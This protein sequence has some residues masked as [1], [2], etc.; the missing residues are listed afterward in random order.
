MPEL[1]RIDPDIRGKD[2]P[3]DRLL[4]DVAGAQHGVVARWQLLAMEVRGGSVDRRI[5]GRRLHPLHRGVYAV[6][7]GRVTKHGR[8]MAAV[9]ACGP[10]ALASHRTAAW[11]WDL[12][13]DNR[14]RTDVTVTGRSAVKRPG[15]IV[16]RPRQLADDDRAIRE[17][18]PCT[19]AAR[20]LLDVAATEPPRALRRAYEEAERRRVLDL[21]DVRR[22]L[23][24][25]RGHRGAGPLR[26]LVGDAT[27]PVPLIRSEVEA[28][29]LDLVRAEGLP[30]PAMNVPFG[31]YELDAVWL[32]RKVVVEIDHY[33][34]HGHRRAFEGDRVRDIELQIAGFRVGRVTDEQIADPRGTGAR[35]RRLLAV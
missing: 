24:G 31:K 7:H 25:A 32:D 27:G 1:G 35:L 20:T 21:R 17:G 19:S 11:L 12:L 4:A 18:I 16:H 30:L 15:I 10:G 33:A 6:G 13:W 9:L 23:D 28:R 26:A 34:T 14:P 3:V 8:V 29:F 22:V 5:A 2:G